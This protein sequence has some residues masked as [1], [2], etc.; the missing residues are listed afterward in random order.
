MYILLLY[1]IIYK[2]IKIYYNKIMSKFDDAITYF[3]NIFFNNIKN[4]AEHKVGATFIGIDTNISGK[5]NYI[6]ILFFFLL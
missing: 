4:P 2:N 6:F 5:M 1:V 3:R